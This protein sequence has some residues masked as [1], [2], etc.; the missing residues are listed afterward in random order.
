MKW[1]TVFPLGE[2]QQIATMLLTC[3]ACHKPSWPLLFARSRADQPIFRCV[4]CSV[5]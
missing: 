2:L 1:S 3:D 5:R 4:P